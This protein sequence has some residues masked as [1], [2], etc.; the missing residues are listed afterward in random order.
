MIITCKQVA[1]RLA[2][3]KMHKMSWLERNWLKMHI[4]LCRVCGDYHRHVEDF[5]IAEDRFAEKEC[6]VTKPLAQD[7]K[8]SLK[9]KLKAQA[10][11]K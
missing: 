11:I 1:K 2:K 7:K 4:G 6:E 10:P 3:R 5:H 8:Q 9:E